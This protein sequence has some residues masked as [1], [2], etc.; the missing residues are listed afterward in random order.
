[1]AYLTEEMI[2]RCKEF[3]VVGTVIGVLPIGEIDGID[4][5][6]GNCLIDIISEALKIAWNES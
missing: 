1:M 5:P 2:R 4:I 6:L 3:V